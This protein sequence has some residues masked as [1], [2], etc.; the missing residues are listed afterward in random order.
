M[1]IPKEDLVTNPELQS[2]IKAEWDSVRVNQP[3]LERIRQPKLKRLE[4]KFCGILFIG[5]Y[6]YSTNGHWLL[7]ILVDGPPIVRDT[8]YFYY[9]FSLEDII[10]NFNP[11]EEYL[12][13][14]FAS[15]NKMINMLANSDNYLYLS[16]ET[17]KSICESVEMVRDKR[18]FVFN[19]NFMDDEIIIR[20]I[21]VKDLCIIYENTLPYIENI[22][23]V[24]TQ[25]N[26]NLAYVYKFSTYLLS[27]NI[28]VVKFAFSG[29]K[30]DPVLIK[31]APVGRDYKRIEFLVSQYLV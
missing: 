11:Y 4:D 29:S 27:E 6:A 31:S 18:Y 30:E 1:E 7:R 13:L 15:M 25:L 19:I 2:L 23:C 14:D 10:E 21:R 22:S 16:T 26:I 5:K 9:S 17:I 8:C 24:G 20:V 28:S 3:M 12:N